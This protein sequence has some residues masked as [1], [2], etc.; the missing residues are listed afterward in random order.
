MSGA[1]AWLIAGDRLH[2]QHGPIDL[3]IGAEGPE[4]ARGA[5]FRAATERF[6][7]ILEA[8]VAE[9]ALLRAPVLA[10]SALPAGAVARRMASACQP[11]RA[12]FVTMMAAVAGAVADEVLEAMR[13]ATPITR[14][15]VNNGGDIALYL[16]E[17]Q[18]YISAMAT[19]EGRDLGRIEIRATD[20][21]RGIA[22]SGQGGRSLSFGIAE[23]VTV[24]AK[25]AAAADVA[26]TLIANAV[27]LPESSAVTRIAAREMQPD[28]D[29]GART[30]V[31]HVGALISS[32]IDQALAAGA[33]V[34]QDML[35]RNLIAG[36]ALFLRGEARFIGALDVPQQQQKKVIYA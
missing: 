12:G 2:L 24:L 30:V 22:T 31:A 25:D 13:A 33:A 28:S 9:Q 29:L 23:S 5:A 26:A 36:A 32:D 4:G 20:S 7:T 15:Y 27:D 35:T 14:A 11:H 1:M 18:R 34:A 8:L 19:P 16:G 6:E 3:I 17:G 10:E 21:A